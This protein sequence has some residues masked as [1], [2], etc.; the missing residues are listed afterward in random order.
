M[1]FIEQ[2]MSLNNLYTF[3]ALLISV[4]ACCSCSFVLEQHRTE[5]LLK[6]QRFDVDEICPPQPIPQELPSEL[7]KEINDSLKALGD[8]ANDSLDKTSLPGI[9]I[10]VT[11]LG[12]SI[13]TKG[14]GVKSKESKSEAP[15]GD[16]IFRIGSVSKIFPVTMIYQLY[17]QQH[18]RSL[19]DP[20]VKYAPDFKIINPFS[21]ADITLRQM[22]S[23][24]SG[25]PREAPCGNATSENV[26]QESTEDILKSLS[27]QMLIHPPWTKP[28]YSNLAYA[29]LGRL[30]V[31]Q[32]DKDTTFED[33]VKRAIID[34]LDL[35][36]TGF[37]ITEDVKSKMA[38]GYGPDG[39]I[40]PLI[41]IGWEAPAGQ[42]YSTVNDL[43]KLSE[44][45]YNAHLLPNSDYKLSKNDVLSADL[46]REMSLPC[47]VNPDRQT[48]FGTPWEI[49]YR[50]NYTIRT[51]GGNIDGYSAMF[52]FIPELH[53]GINALFSGE[54]D[55]ISFVPAAFDIILPP[56]VN[57]LIKLKPKIGFPPDPQVY[58]GTYSALGVEVRIFSNN[59]V[60]YGTNDGKT[61]TTM[62][63]K[64][65]NRM[66]LYPDSL[67]SCLVS[68]LTASQGEWVYFDPNYKSGKS[69]GFMIPGLYQDVY[70]KR[71]K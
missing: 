21:S 59:N 23:Q 33:Y 51:K 15:E 16:T 43:N 29:L 12:K 67:S 32:V 25:L 3:Y 42:M 35:E 70:F 11:Y 9:A 44:F 6:P 2:G 24:L 63:Y 4:I 58:I 26:C 38:V 71:I 20:L 10:S 31:R 17:A 62:D 22:A 53:L 8:L 54:F 36:N 13:W 65:K 14:F 30:M 49:F 56:I 69:P 19:D 47:F 48:G 40:A 61:N 41:D 68:E 64:D 45:F 66:Q 52:S 18:I 34:P 50:G 28:S 39:S 7:T 1:F 60:I 46:R 57:Y 27:S 55:G 37:K 5:R